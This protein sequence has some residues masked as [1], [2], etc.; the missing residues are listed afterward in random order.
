MSTYEVPEYVH[1]NSS[2][3]Q[4]HVGLGDVGIGGAIVLPDNVIPIVW[5]IVGI[6]VFFAFKYMLRAADPTPR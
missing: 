2:K 1:G 6:A 3:R 5:G 4:P